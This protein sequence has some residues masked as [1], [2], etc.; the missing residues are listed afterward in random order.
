MST[1]AVTIKWKKSAFIVVD[2]HVHTHEE[3]ILSYLFFRV[4]AVKK[5]SVDGNKMFLK[6]A[7]NSLEYFNGIAK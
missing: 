4:G 6:I 2:F 1:A 3:R 5:A 7:L